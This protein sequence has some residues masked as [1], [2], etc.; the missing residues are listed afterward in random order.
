MHFRVTSTALTQR[1]IHFAAHH[2]SN[3]LRYQE[4][5]ASGLQFQRPSEQPISFRQVTSLR[6]RFAELEAD[7]S[8]IDRTT[9]VLN[10]SV[11][12]IQ[13]YTDLI[14]Q[15]KIATQQ[16]IQA[17]DDDER[18]ALALEVDGL[19]DQLK[20]IGLA[21][22]NDRYLYGGTKSGSPPFE[23]REPD[24]PAQ[25]LTVNY[26]G[27]SQRS[28]A[29]VGDSI[30]V[31]TYYDGSEVFGNAGRQSTLLF[32]LTGARVGTGTDTIV[33]RASLQVLHDTTTYLGGS[34]ILPGTDSA[35]GDTIIG[36]A[37]SHQLTIVDTAGDGSAGTITLNG[38]PPVAFTSADTNLRV[39]GP[40]GASSLRRHQQYHGRLQ[41][42]D[43]YR[44]DGQAEC[45]QWR[46]R[47]GD[48][49]HHQSST[50]GQ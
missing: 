22:F 40:D 16:G 44:I 28:R 18:N 14:K 4:Q 23:F 39:A 11:S 8:A 34:G 31:D 5:I 48:R 26:F 33:G 35:S 29:S 15:A 50:H 2:S 27:S 9:S 41:W 7:R 13:D 12:Q 32:G 45:R 21:Q 36:Q 10:A 46:F 6:T 1:A 38:G 3:V 25:T 20:S 49:L 37:G 30:A 42:N 24:D 47:F 19:L 43:R 17:I